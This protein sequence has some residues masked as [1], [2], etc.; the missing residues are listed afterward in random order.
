MTEE[1][2]RY[3]ITAKAIVLTLQLIAAIAT[4]AGVVLL[5]ACVN[6]NM[7]NMSDLGDSQFVGSGY[8]ERTFSNQMEN[9]LTY[10]SLKARFE[11]DGRYDEGL[12]MSV[13]ASEEEIEQYKMFSN[14]YDQGG[15]NLYYW[16]GNESGVTATNMDQ[17]SG[18]EDAYGRAMSLGQYVCYNSDTFSFDTNIGGVERDY[19]RNMSLYNIIAGNKSVLIVAVDES[20]P[21]NDDLATAKKEFEKLY[22]WAMRSLWLITGGGVLW[23]F[24]LCYMTV[25]AGKSSEDLDIHLMKPDRIKTEIPA[26]ILLLSAVSMSLLVEK[27]RQQ[28]YGTMGRLVVVITFTVLMDVLFMGLYLSLVR[29]VKGDIF[30]E[31]SIIHWLLAGT[32][33]ALTSRYMGLA[34]V[35]QIWGLIAADTLLAWLAFARGLIW[36]LVLLVIFL[37]FTAIYFSQRAIERRQILDAIKWITE[38]EIDYKL[39]TEQFHADERKLA[40]GINHIGEGLS[41]AIGESVRD[42]RMKANMITNISHDIKTPLTSIINY[43]GLLEREKIDNPNVQTYLGVLKSKSMRLKQLMEDLME[44]SRISSGNISL[45]MADIDLV[46]LV[47]QTGGEFNER[48][49]QKG[50]NVITKLPQDTCMIYADGQQ[51]WRVISNLYNNVAKY[52]MPDTRVYVEVSRTEHHAAFSIRNISEAEL[53]V[54]A[55][56]LAERFVRGDEARSTEGSGLGLSISKMLTE[57]MGGRFEI[58]LDDDLF[59]VRVTFRRI[60]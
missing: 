34:G 36:A 58:D 20:F 9:L 45:S 38:G 52:A 22:P 29:R 3:S 50:L 46:E 40:D 32:R 41:E 26:V 42:E 24:C 55:N 27:M 11:E 2:K 19:Y 49:E 7:L 35:L 14:K 47:R 6:N 4:A 30:F 25:V 39:N 43:I 23:L 13:A 17:V 10:L 33:E 37:L 8:F 44:V 18:M 12:A 56:A 59:R 16:L 31:N 57:L 28:A 21:Q 48:F 51:M 1:R 15:T 54:D 53:H 60:G 5:S